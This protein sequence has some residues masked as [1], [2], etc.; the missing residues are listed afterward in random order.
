MTSRNLGYLLR[1]AKTSPASVGDPST[2]HPRP[3]VKH[4]R[5]SSKLRTHHSCEIGIHSVTSEGNVSTN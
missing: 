2:S 1:H 3:P 4:A 5:G